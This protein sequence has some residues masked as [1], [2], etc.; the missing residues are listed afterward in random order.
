[1]AVNRIKKISIG[2]VVL[3]ISLFLLSHRSSCT[4][5]SLNSG[6]SAIKTQNKNHVHAFSAKLSD[7]RVSY[8]TIKNSYWISSDFSTADITNS[9]FVNLNVL[10]GSFNKA[11]IV[12]NNITLSVFF[13]T[14]FSDTEMVGN[15]V[16]NSRFVGVNFSRAYFHGTRFVN[17]DFDG[18]DFRSA[19]LQDVV[20]LLSNLRGAF[21]D[22]QTQLPFSREYA[23]AQGMIYVQ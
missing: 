6:P 17:C 18:A 19:N 20:F 16:E 21:F 13:K 4:F 14:D 3:S 12:G 9:A 2:I 22:S 5:S 11:K 8:S 10:Y 1:M 15:L 7:F 23:L